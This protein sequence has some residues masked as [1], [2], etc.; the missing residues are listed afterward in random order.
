MKKIMLFIGGYKLL[1]ADRRDAARIMNICRSY[2][3]IYRDTV[4]EGDN[5]FFKCS[6]AASGRLKKRC[7]EAGIPLFEER[8]YGIPS[9]LA[10]YRRRYGVLAGL[11]LFAAIIFLSGRVIWDIRVDG[12]V[13][14]SEDEVI[15]QL[16]ECG[17]SV[18]DIR[19]G[20]DTATVEN[21]VMIASGDISW[22]SINIIGTVAQVE[23]RES[24]VIPEQGEE[25]AAS[26]IVAARDGYIELFE[27]VR[28]NVILNIGDYVR[29]GELIVSGLYDSKTAGI[30]YTNAR[31][32]VLARVERDIRAEIPLSYEKKVYTGR[33]FTEK[34]LI[35]F[36]KE[37]KFCGNSGNSYES[38]D[39]INTVEYLDIF[40]AGELPVGIR[41][42]KHLEYTYER[43][44][45]TPEE[46]EALA[47]YKLSSELGALMRDR[48][49]IR[50]SV[51][52]GLTDTAFVL[53]CRLEC[54]EDIARIKKIEIEGLP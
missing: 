52:G 23:I 13:R 51:S 40:S 2:G 44:E 36:E 53:E 21:R 6:L 26:N 5:I 9:L 25:Y 45:R 31:G 19:R 37:I 28:G 1:G 15:A 33:V 42:V 38:C 48:E 18:G 50:K 27:D 16:G 46:A 29:E 14:L 30:R 41:T 8:A 49:L 17:L 7:A 10:R 39:T 3:I 35:F 24:E 12:N 47:E 32:R 22:M 34:Y 54:I 20:V 43:A 11:F 4:F